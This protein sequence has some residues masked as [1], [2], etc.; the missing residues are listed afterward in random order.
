MIVMSGARLDLASLREDAVITERFGV[1][2][3]NYPLLD[4]PSS[5]VLDLFVLGYTVPVALFFLGIDSR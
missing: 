2:P 5:A 4:L 3:P 1:A